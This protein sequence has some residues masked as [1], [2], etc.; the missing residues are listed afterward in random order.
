MTRTV[1]DPFVI[2]CTR[3]P[4]VESHH[5]V[6]AAV[7]DA[8]G[9]LVEAWGDVE[10]PVFARS[11]VKSIQVLPLFE[12]GAAEQMAL[13]DAEIAIGCASHNGQPAHLDCVRNWLN[14]CGLDEDDLECGGH[15]PLHEPT[16]HARLREGKTAHAIFNNCSGKHS[17][18]LVTAKTLGEPTAG[19]VEATHPV[20]RRVAAV[21]GEMTGCDISRAPWAIDGCSIP[22]FA[23][24]LR[25]I[26]LGAARIADPSGLASERR[27]AVQRIRAAIAAEPF[28]IAGDDRS[29]S[30]IIRESGG[31]ALAKIGAEGMFFV[32][33][34]TLGRGLALKVRDG[35]WRATEVAVTALLARLGVLDEAEQERL[36]HYIEAPVTNWRG[37]Q[38]GEL[39]A[40]FD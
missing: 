32:A 9:R 14:R 6:D 26:A 4:V 21:L 12:T 20:Q 31:K 11:A 30:A 22:T 18:F 8:D 36:S 10:Q 19:Y 39:R 37:R 28:M 5:L 33:L 40:V 1:R 35:A 3:G 24:P 38:V 13:S 2:E 34:P 17:A 29:C 27:K 23:L 7:V 15:W 25:A 16:A